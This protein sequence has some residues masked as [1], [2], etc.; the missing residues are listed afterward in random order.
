MIYKN[1]YQQSFYRDIARHGGML[2]H[3]NSRVITA[4]NK[5]L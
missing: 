2:K 1:I 5:N 4:L 3:G